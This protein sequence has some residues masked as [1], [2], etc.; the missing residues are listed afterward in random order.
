MHWLLWMSFLMTGIFVLAVVLFASCWWVIFQRTIHR[1]N[2][3]EDGR[4]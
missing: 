2:A 1:F 3:E 4:D